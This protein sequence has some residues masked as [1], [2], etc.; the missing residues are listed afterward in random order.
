MLFLKAWLRYTYI[1][2]RERDARLIAYQPDGGIAAMT[3]LAEDT[4]SAVVVLVVE[5]NGMQVPRSIALG[6]L[7][8]IKRCSHKK[9]SAVMR[10]ILK[11]NRW[12]ANAISD[13]LY[14]Y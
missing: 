9:K 14:N 13:L 12:L 6:A 11:D 10:A 7:F 8:P 2:Y 3:Q 5:V 1:C 4:I